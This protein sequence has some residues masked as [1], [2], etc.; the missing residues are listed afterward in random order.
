MITVLRPGDPVD[1]FPDP[2]L[3]L[4]EPDGLL[5]MGGD[6]SAARLLAAYRRGI[7]PWYGPGD[8]ILWWSPDPRAVLRP[9]AVHCSRRLARSMRKS[10][11]RASLDEDFVAVL[12]GCAAPRGPD[13]GTWLVADM[14]A[15]Y[16]R[17]HR[18][19]VA[20]SFELWDAERL[21]GGLY[22]LAL[23]RVFFAESMFSR[24]PDASKMLLV[25]AGE[26][27]ARRGFRLIDAQVASP[28]L[29][30]MGAELWPR[31]RF[32]KELAGALA[33]EP[34]EPLEPLDEDLRT[35]AGALISRA[36][37]EQVPAL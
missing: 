34:S 22:G 8:P 18:L 7:F 31:A 33:E 3:A 12:E 4:R 2:A 26:Q 15:A 21:I 16:A 17:L 36:A 37:V 11:F 32:M 20:H 13:A 10:A 14:Q 28:H 9:G 23:G 24:V 29:L 19:G 30:R 5:A 27:L 35:P 25:I 6:L 1:G